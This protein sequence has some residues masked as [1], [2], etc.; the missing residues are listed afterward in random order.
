MNNKF[1]SGF[2]IFLV[3]FSMLFLSA[4]ATTNALDERDPWEGFNRGVYTLQ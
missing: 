1:V 3:G 4:C 2:K